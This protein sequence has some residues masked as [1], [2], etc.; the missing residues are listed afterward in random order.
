MNPL[1]TRRDRRELRKRELRTN[2][3]CDPFSAKKVHFCLSGTL[4]LFA[5]LRGRRDML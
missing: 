5:F 3:V 1:L 4:I 2:A